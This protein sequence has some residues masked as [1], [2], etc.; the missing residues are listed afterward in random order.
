M[1][2]FLPLVADGTVSYQSCFETDSLTADPYRLVL[3]WARSGD[4][5]ARW[6]AAWY[7]PPAGPLPRRSDGYWQGISPDLRVISI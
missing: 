3:T 4:I 7:P 6:R 5:P 2:H 1:T